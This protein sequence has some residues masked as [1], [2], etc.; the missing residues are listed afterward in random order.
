MKDKSYSLFQ[1]QGKGINMGYGID[2]FTV[3]LPIYVCNIPFQVC[4]ILWYFEYCVFNFDNMFAN[5]RG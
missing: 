2:I 1:I 4:D 5:F 3:F